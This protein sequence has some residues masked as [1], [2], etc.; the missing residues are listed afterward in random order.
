MRHDILVLMLDLCGV[1]G[2]PPG[3]GVPTDGDGGDEEE[4]GD[5]G[6]VDGGGDEVFAGVAVDGVG[7]VGAAFAACSCLGVS[8]YSRMEDMLLGHSCCFAEK[9]GKG[10]NGYIPALQITQSGFTL[11]RIDFAS[12]SLLTNSMSSGRVFRANTLSF[13]EYDNNILLI[14]FKTSFAW[15]GSRITD[16]T[17]QPRKQSRGVIFRATLPWPPMRRILGI[18]DVNVVYLVLGR[19]NWGTGVEEA[20]RGED[21]GKI[22]ER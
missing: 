12:F 4:F 3:G 9:T 1:G 2:G 8:I 11:S 5:G 20:E 22:Q 10:N 16:V 21:E 7:A 19:M 15:L 6:G 18:F 17:A 13:P 14:E